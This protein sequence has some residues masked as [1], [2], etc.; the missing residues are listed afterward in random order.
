MMRRIGEPAPGLQEIVQSSCWSIWEGCACRHL[1][2]HFGSHSCDD[3]NCRSTWTTEQAEAW[4]E[5]E[6]ASR[7]VNDRHR[8]GDQ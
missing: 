2:N 8:G 4:A 3:P 1:K 6:R 7:G 5:A